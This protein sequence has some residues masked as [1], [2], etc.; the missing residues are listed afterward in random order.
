MADGRTPR[1][2]DVVVLGGG[3]AGLFCAAVA[4]GR[5]RRVLVLERNARVGM[6]V[7]ISGGGRANFTNR[8]VTADNFVSQNP[9]FARSALARYTPDDFLALVE[10]HRI[11]W[12]E[13]K[14]GQLFCRDSAKAITEMLLEECHRARVEIR[15]GCRVAD[16]ARL[17]AEVA[18]AAPRFGVRLEGGEALACRSLVVATG[19]L[20]YERLGAS[21]LGY[22]IARQHGLAIVPPRPGLVPLLWTR[23]ERPRWDELAGVA[24]PARVECGGARFEEALLFTHGGLSGPAILQ[25]SNYWRL[26]E[27]VRID[28]LPGADL[29]DELLQRKARGDT[30]SAAAV[31]AERL[32]RRLAERLVPAPL[33]VRPLAQCAAADLAALAEVVQRFRFQPA[34]DAGYDKAEVTLGGVDTAELSSRTLE[35]RR[36]PGLYFIGE[37]VD[38]TG[39][40]GGYNFQWAWASAHAAG[41]AV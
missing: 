40:L 26:G 24:T 4:A 15:T 41:E 37:V 33:A 11:P 38:V 30:A 31:L 20:S 21:D 7:L 35:A 14:H 22:R 29:R 9:D 39:W 3:A 2:W 6:K 34:E 1:G 5:G 19:G 28:L 13:R 27:S 12:V 10:R 36:A 32:P 17:A 18:D 25:I 16:V 23:A 8:R